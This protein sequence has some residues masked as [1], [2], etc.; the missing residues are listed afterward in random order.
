MGY[1]LLREN[2][3]GW[4]E[5]RERKTG[6]RE[7]REKGTGRR[8][9]MAVL[10]IPMEARS[11]QLRLMPLTCHLGAQEAI[12]FKIHRNRGFPAS[13]GKKKAISAYCGDFK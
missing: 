4:G 1:C 8:S 9:H 3:R 5:K 13:G 6:R 2:E 10:V 7:G 11:R 12:C